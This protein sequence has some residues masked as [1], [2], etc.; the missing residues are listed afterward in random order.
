LYVFWMKKQ[1][2]R[3]EVL[4]LCIFSG[5]KSHESCVI[6][7]IEPS[8]SRS[9]TVTLRWK[10]TSFPKLLVFLHL[11]VARGLK[12]LATSCLLSVALESCGGCLLGDLYTEAS[13]ICD[14][15]EAIKEG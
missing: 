2:P 8:N 9:G 11:L 10:L 3:D 12:R 6:G 1:S 15:A 7:G 5:S 13:R 4:T 14:L